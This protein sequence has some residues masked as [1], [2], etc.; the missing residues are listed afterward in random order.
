VTKQDLVDAVAKRLG[1]TKARAGEI[2]ELF[3]SESGLIAAE[4][5]RGGRVTVSG[6]GTFEVRRRAAREG[7]N[8]RTGKALSIK[9]AT[10]PAFRAARG[11]RDLVNRKR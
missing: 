5:R 3:F 4:L 9:A 1:V 8:P 11:L 2:T 7:R 6:F 10:V